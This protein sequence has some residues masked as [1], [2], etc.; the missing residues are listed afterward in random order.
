MVS[1]FDKG[2][3]PLVA[4]SQPGAPT[5]SAASNVDEEQPALPVP[6]AVAAVHKDFIEPAEHSDEEGD[7]T[8]GTRGWGAVDALGPAS[9]W[10]LA[11][12][13]NAQGVLAAATCWTFRLFVWH[14]AQALGY[15][16]CVYFFRTE[17]DPLQHMLALA[18]AGREALHLCGVL[19]CACLNPSVLLLDLNA[20]AADRSAP[21]PLGGAAVI[22]LSVF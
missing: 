9:S 10:R 22:A 21:W 1:G 19:L 3:Q 12:E 20:A 17:L 7:A 8:A 4:P 6:E 14:V 18:V 11:R 5:A 15:G 13:R 16:A 2:G